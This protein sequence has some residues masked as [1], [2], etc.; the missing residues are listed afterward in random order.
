MEIDLWPHNMG[1]ILI[2]I[3][4]TRDQLLFTLL[5]LSLSN[6]MCCP[7]LCRAMLAIIRIFYLSLPPSPLHCTYALLYDCTH[8]VFSLSLSSLF[9]HF[10]DF[11][12]YHRANNTIKIVSYGWLGWLF[13]IFLSRK[14]WSLSCCRYMLIAQVRP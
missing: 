13:L 11:F 7:V 1:C 2:N 5:F 14:L 8:C 10:F 9:F 3:N 6:W 12:H 4:Q